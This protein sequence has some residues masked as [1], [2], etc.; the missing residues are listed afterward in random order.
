MDALLA[1]I[2][3][4][5]SANFALSASFDHPRIEFAP[6]HKIVALRYGGF[7]KGQWQTGAPLGFPASGD[8]VSIYDDNA[9]A[10]Y[11]PEDWK[12]RSPAELSVLVHEMV[13]HLQNVGGLRFECPQQREQ[14]AYEAQE[15][16]LAL[17]GRDLS[18]DFGMDRLSILVKSKCFY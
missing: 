17:F 8:I 4:W 9:R 15:R 6:P 14:L 10:I 3:V 18:G 2:V 7:T 11:L 12:G 13:H 16:W 5:L 1:A